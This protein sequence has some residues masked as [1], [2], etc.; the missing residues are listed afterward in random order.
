[1]HSIFKKRGC[2]TER[3][4]RQYLSDELSDE[5]RY[6]V[7]NH[8]LDCELCSAAVDGLSQSQG[9]GPAEEDVQELRARVADSARGIPQRWITWI[10][11]AAAVGLLLILGYAGL[12]YWSASRP[13]RLFA[14]HFETAANTY[15]TYRS[16]DDDALNAELKRALEYYDARAFEYSLPHFSNYL[17]A[18]PQDH[19]ATLLAACAY[20]QA[21]Q[22]QP[23]ERYLIQLETLGMTYQGQTLW[24][25]ALAHL[26]QG[27]MP[28][29]RAMLERV[30][31]EA[32]P[33]FREKAEALLK[34]IQ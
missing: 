12:R 20:L 13:E 24:Y 29:A 15:I 28:K 21:G 16:T 2:L 14:A 31:A 17:A 30:V 4:V 25:L 9:F 11:R 26:R 27:E 7:E 8:L 22:P 10:N 23:A 3:E 18:N 1:M 19:R 33:P 32:A 6:D 34:E 5:Q